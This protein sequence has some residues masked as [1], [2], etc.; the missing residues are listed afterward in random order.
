MTFEILGAPIGKR[1]PRFSTIH[2]YAQA[3]KPKEDVIYENLVKITFQA[4]KSEGYDLYDK[5]IRMTIEAQF[6]VPKSFSKR[7]AVVASEGG[8]RP[9]TKP[10]VDN[11]A[12]IICDALNGIAYK[13]DTQIVALTVSKKYAVEPKVIVTVEEY[14]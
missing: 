9:L 2:G 3:I 10:D 7:K 14:R 12:K 5:P 1:R 6:S 13:D 11:I 8:I 4:A